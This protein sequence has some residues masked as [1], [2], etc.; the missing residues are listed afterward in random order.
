[1]GNKKKK[2]KKHYE[3]NGIYD[4]E[5]S[6]KIAQDLSEYI[7]CVEEMIIIENADEDEVKG[8]I[9]Y[10]K[11]VCKKLRTGRE[12]EVFNEDAYIEAMQNQGMNIRDDD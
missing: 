4:H 11:K 1:M 6:C 3:S 2:K 10:L 7:D 12:S 5:T 9:K 8:A